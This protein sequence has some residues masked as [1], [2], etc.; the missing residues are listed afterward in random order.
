MLSLLIREIPTMIFRLPDFGGLNG[1]ELTGTSGLEL[2][3]SMLFH[4]DAF[5]CDCFA[6]LSLDV[7][8]FSLIAVHA[9]CIDFNGAELHIANFTFS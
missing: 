3:W 6:D 8:P 9:L 4:Y 5:R 2:G 1:T 7:S